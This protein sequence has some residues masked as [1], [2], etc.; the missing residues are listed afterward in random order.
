M[1]MSYLRISKLPHAS[2]KFQYYFRENLVGFYY[3]KA[4]SRPGLSY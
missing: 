3:T 4:K 2:V 1:K